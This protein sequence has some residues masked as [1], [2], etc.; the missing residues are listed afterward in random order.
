[1]VPPDKPASTP[2]NGSMVAKL[3]GLVLRFN[4]LTGIEQVHK[5]FAV[6][7]AQ[8]FYRIQISG[9]LLLG[10]FCQRFP[11][12][13]PGGTTG[14]YNAVQVRMKANVLPPSVEHS[15]VSALRAKVLGILG[16]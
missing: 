9:I 6:R 2:V 10:S 15:N 16:K 3:V 4:I 5:Y 7:F 8:G 14:R 1:M 11:V 13:L 12:A